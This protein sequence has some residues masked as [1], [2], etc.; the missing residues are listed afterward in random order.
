M[1]RGVVV[2]IVVDCGVAAAIYMD[3]APRTYSPPTRAHWP[4]CPF[5]AEHYEE[6]EERGTAVHLRR[7]TVRPA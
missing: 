5:H 1:A 6:L 4:V 7:S 3:A 2:C